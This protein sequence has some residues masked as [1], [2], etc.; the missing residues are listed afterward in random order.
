M[1]LP[2]V[3]QYVNQL[4]GLLEQ[5]DNAQ[6]TVDK[7][8][9]LMRAADGAG[10]RQQQLQ[11]A[12]QRG[13]FEKQLAALDKALADHTRRPD[14]EGARTLLIDITVRIDAAMDEYMKWRRMLGEFEWSVEQKLFA[15]EPEEGKEAAGF[16]R[17]MAEAELEKAKDR[18]ETRV[19]LAG[20]AV[21]DRPVV[22]L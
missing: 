6:A 21:P 7:I 1:N 22:L 17:T 2:S 15:A 14:F 3:R 13:A 4:S 8:T 12:Q 5:R 18:A 20:R 11:L 9:A 10:E 16:T 19:A